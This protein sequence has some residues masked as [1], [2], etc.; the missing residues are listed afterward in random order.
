NR[1][2][3][4]DDQQL[5]AVVSILEQPE[6]SVPFIIYGLPG[7]GKTSIVVESIVQLVRRDAGVRILACAPSDAAADLLAERLAAAGLDSDKLYRL[8]SSSHYEEDISED[9][10]ISSLFPGHE[11]LLAFRVVL[12]TCSSAAMLQTLNVP[13]GHFSHIVID[14]ASQA[15]EPLVMIPIAA[16]SNAYTNIILAGDPNQLGPHIRSPTAAK[17]GLWKS[18]LQRLMLIRQVYGL[19]TQVGKTIVALL[20]NRRSHGAILAWSNRYLYE[21]TMR[22]Y[23]IAHTTYHLVDSGVLPKKGFPIVFHGVKANEQRTKWSP[24]YFNILEAS[25]VRDYCVKL[26]RDPERKIYPEEIAVLT[27]YKAQ[28]R[29]IRELLKVAKLSGIQVGPVE[30]FQ[31]Q[32]RKVIILATTRSNEENHAQTALGS[33]L[34]RQRT[35]VA[36]T[37]AQALLIVIGDPEVLGKDGLWRTFLNYIKSR[38]GWTGKS[39]NWKAEEVV[40][41][42]GYKLVPR[43]GGVVYG[44]E[45]I[46]GKS[47]KVYRSS[48]SGGG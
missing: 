9:L 3:R 47:E 5:Q 28:V 19:D 23:G 35:N 34:N 36:I 29:A 21:D 17:A 44:D 31:G 18:Y 27:P 13:V 46:G 22:D 8:N 26:I 12:S 30:Q 48:E 1:D 24:S 20:R 15:E 25:I 33:L 10:Q 41:L 11:R 38:K 14:E 4:D 16:F 40:H 42:P 37:R 45:F 39:Q 2:I 6:G 7:T 43:Q 32:E